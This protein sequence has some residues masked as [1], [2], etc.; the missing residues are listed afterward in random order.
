MFLT[1][2]ATVLPVP[3]PLRGNGRRLAARPKPAD[4]AAAAAESRQLPR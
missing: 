3:R 4:A 1:S 2:L